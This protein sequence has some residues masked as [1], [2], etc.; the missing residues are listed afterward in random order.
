M[1]KKVSTRDTERVSIW[2]AISSYA[3]TRS[4]LHAFN[5]KTKWKP[6]AGAH[7]PIIK[8]FRFFTKQRNKRTKE[9]GKNKMMKENLIWNEHNL[10]F[11]LIFS[12]QSAAWTNKSPPL[13]QI[14]H[15]ISFLHSETNSTEKRKWKWFANKIFAVA[16]A[17][18]HFV[19]AKGK[20]SPKIKAI[21][22]FSLL[23]WLQHRIIGCT[24]HNMLWLWLG[25][26]YRRAGA[27]VYRRCKKQYRRKRRKKV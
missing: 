9:K 19:Q 25:L 21:T 8:Q 20:N 12:M 17:L 3:S 11:I 23:L 5:V 26:A 6:Y 24:A 10:D 2:V 27:P 22:I 18:R 13:P 7:K 16:V 15:N 14:K 1:N 4:N